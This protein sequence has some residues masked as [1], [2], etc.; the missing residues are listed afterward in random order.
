[1]KLNFKDVNS[2]W[3]CR[4]KVFNIITSFNILASS[5]IVLLTSSQI[6]YLPPFIVGI[7]NTYI[8]Q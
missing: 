6:V 3:M 8:D 5:N 7:A 1:M 4:Y 2:K